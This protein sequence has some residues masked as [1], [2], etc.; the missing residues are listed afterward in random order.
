MIIPFI[1]QQ[2]KDIKLAGAKTYFSPEKVSF[3]HL[4][5]SDLEKILIEMVHIEDGF[6]SIFLQCLVEWLDVFARS[7]S[8]Y[9]FENRHANRSRHQRRSITPRE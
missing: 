6:G 7:Q 4:H 3:P 2:V 5:L 8:Q 1:P 9:N